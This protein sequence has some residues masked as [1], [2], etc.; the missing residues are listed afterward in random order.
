MPPGERQ[1]IADVHLHLAPESQAPALSWVTSLRFFSPWMTAVPAALVLQRMDP[2]GSDRRLSCLQIRV[3]I[4]TGPLAGS[5]VGVKRNSLTLVG[6]TLVRRQTR[7]DRDGTARDAG[8]RQPRS[9]IDRR[10]SERVLL[11]PAEH[12]IEDGVQLAACP[13]PHHPGDFSELVHQAHAP[14]V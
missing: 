14:E 2:R 1:G 12:G 9:V 7:S 3:G 5:T 13:H 4:H 10:A 8:E 11:V 6:D